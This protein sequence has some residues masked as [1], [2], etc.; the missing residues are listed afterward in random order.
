MPFLRCD[1]QVVTI[2]D[3]K[4]AHFHTAVLQGIIHFWDADWIACHTT[5]FT[6]RL[7]GRLYTFLNAW[8]SL[9]RD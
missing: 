5:L 2:L 7:S 6:D 9:F 3:N 1:L 8:G 4:T